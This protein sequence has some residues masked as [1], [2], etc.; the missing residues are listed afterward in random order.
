MSEKY[1]NSSDIIPQVFKVLI[2]L[3]DY[4]IKERMIGLHSTLEALKKSLTTRYD[5][6]LKS[7]NNIKASF[8]DPR[9]KGSIFTKEPEG[10]VSHISNIEEMIIEE[11]I[12]HDEREKAAM[13]QRHLEGTS[14][15]GPG[16]SLDPDDPEESA[17]FGGFEDQDFDIDTFLH[18][19]LITETETNADQDIQDNTEPN[20][21]TV[22]LSRLNI[23]AEL[24]FYKQQP[25]LP[26]DGSVF[27]WWKIHQE[28]LPCLSILARKYLSCPPSS[29]ESERVFSIGGNIYTP[30]RNRLSPEMGE[31]LMFLN[32]NLRL[33]PKLE[34]D[35]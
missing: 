23:Q 2:Y 11:Y 33:L 34:Y 29:V 3:N 9:Y 4:F 14:E 30:H 22:S 31:M 8:L 19:R 35:L 1:A 25:L 7:T 20:L 28:K 24:N 27:K 13:N 26:K 32:Y 16:P 5:K 10:S 17:E 15:I 12:R 6:Y 21:Q 18:A